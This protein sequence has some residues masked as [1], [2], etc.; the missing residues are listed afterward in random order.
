MERR[1]GSEKISTNNHIHMNVLH[2]NS[3]KPCGYESY[4][5]NLKPTFDMLSL[6]T[7]QITVDTIQSN[8]P[9]L[10]LEQ[11]QRPPQIQPQLQS[12]KVPDDPVK[13]SVLR[14]AR[15]LATANNVLM[16]CRTIE[17]NFSYLDDQCVD[18]FIALANSQK[19]G[20]QM[21]STICAQDPTEEYE[22]YKQTD[23]ESSLD[24]IQIIFEGE[25]GDENIGH[26]ICIFYEAERQIVFVYDSLYRKKLSRRA[27]KILRARY[28]N[29]VG[30][31]FILPKTTQPDGQTCGVFAIAYATSLL[32]GVDPAKYELYLNPA[33]IDSTKDLRMHLSNMLR[34][35]DITLF[36]SDDSD[37]Y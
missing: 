21:I 8:Q 4:Y 3:N 18:K 14:V 6:E 27:L 20:N 34:N 16:M 15:E 32:Y 9:S 23:V 29:Y 5:Y 1:F 11:L 22:F 26:F 36:P 12:A 24:D 28:P 37:E 25:A 7:P 30:Y 33:C 31:V 2:S 35:N 19:S 17:E 10:L 13:K